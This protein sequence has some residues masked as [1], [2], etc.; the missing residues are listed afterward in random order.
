MNEESVKLLKSPMEFTQMLNVTEKWDLCALHFLL[1]IY[2][3][4][5]IL[6]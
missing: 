2:L 6:L 5:L 4:F 1:L 3:N